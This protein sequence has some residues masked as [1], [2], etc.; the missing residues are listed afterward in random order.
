MTCI[1]IDDE[2][3]AIAVLTR[4]LDKVP[5]LE[6]LATFDRPLEGLAFLKKNTPDCIFLDINM[7][8]INGLELTRFLQK[9]L[10]I[11]TTAYPQYAL[12]SY[13]VNAVDYLLKPISF[14]RFLK[15]VEKLLECQQQRITK[16]VVLTIKSSTKT[17][18]IQAGDIDY[19]ES[20]GNNI[21]FHT[22][23]ENITARMTIAE[24]MT[25]PDMVRIHKSF[26]V[27]KEKI[28]VIESHQVTTKSGAK[29]PIGA[30]YREQ[31]KILKN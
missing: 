28:H 16:P 9:T 13:D 12:E 7:P 11:F 8:D 14:T 5:E 23:S 31:L 20:Q 27:P 19:L 15:G 1:I 25:I 4:Y 6:L 29:L 17:Y 22:T 10:V 24:V 30:V 3:K 18:R 2:P 21:I 26:L